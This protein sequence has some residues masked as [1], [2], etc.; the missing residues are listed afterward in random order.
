MCKTICY[1]RGNFWYCPDCGLWAEINLEQC[2]PGESDFIYA[3]RVKHVYEF[4]FIKIE[5]EG[6]EKTEGKYHC[7]ERHP[8]QEIKL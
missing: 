1:D 2:K 7:A 3:G 8:Q 6:T 5:C 4:K